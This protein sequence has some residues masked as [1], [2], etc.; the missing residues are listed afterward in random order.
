M[1]G[2]RFRS[3]AALAA[4][5]AVLSAAP[6]G[7]FAAAADTGSR[8]A[9]SARAAAAGAAAALPPFA[10]SSYKVTAK[11]LPYTYRPGCP[12]PPSQLRMLHV[13]FVGFDG[14]KHIGRIVVK[15][16][17][18]LKVA[19]VFKKL[20]NARFPI[21]RMMPVDMYGG[22]DAA[23]MAANNTSAF[24]CRA[25]TGGSSWSQH[26]YGWAIDINPVQN[27]YVSGSSVQPA[28]G[29]SYLARSPYRKGM[30][31][32]GGVVDRAFTAAGWGWGGRWNSPKDYQH[33][34]ATNR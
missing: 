27:P 10:W 4:V 6:A 19:G 33:F 9:V 16:T 18:V 14:L 23:S 32:S 12:I 20:Y 21:R 26:S 13:Y 3:L 25:V 8:A 7:P 29:R 22:S 28:A 15:S 5:V 11:D 24:N 30:V 31:L 2:R 17:Q 34:S 1:V